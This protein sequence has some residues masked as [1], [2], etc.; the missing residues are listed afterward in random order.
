MKA[1][2]WLLLTHQLPNEPSNLRVKVWR[3]LQALGAV[4]VKNS[5]YALPNRAASRED[6]EWLR[7][8]IVQSGGEATVFSADSVLEKDDQEMVRSFQHARDEDYAQL[9]K[10][11]RAFS[12]RARAALDGGHLKAQTLDRL[13]RD[14]AEL[15]AERDRIGKID[16]FDTPGRRS[17]DQEFK[18]GGT[19]LARARTA[20]VRRAPAPPPRVPIQ[21]LKGKVW[22]TR[23]SPHVDRLAAAWLVRRF[24]DAKARFKFVIPPYHSGA[25]E[26]RFD[27][28]E[29]EFTH[30][31]DWCT[32]ETLLHRLGLEGPALSTL[33]EIVHDVD[34]KDRK[35][36][37][38][39]A[40]GIALAI[41]GL[42]R[43]YA[44][45]HARVAAGVD[46]FEGVYSALDAEA[47]K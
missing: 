13:E 19:I 40:A 34:L 5:I 44:E 16:F 36:G 33:S 21:S 31:G 4:A 14:W 32:F 9:R 41:R 39:E 37:R 45:D 47:L 26:I 46:F 11:A 17:A 6:F 27:M 7:K 8:D 25:D 3:K 18:R 12:E 29:A 42:C 24:V 35:F 28:P 10:N 15:Q 2:Q 22:V 23:K 43:R 1:P 38:P 30:F 20:S